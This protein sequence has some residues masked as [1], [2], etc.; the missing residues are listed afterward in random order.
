MS[1]KIHD[2]EEVEGVKALEG[3]CRK[4]ESEAAYWEAQYRVLDRHRNAHIASVAFALGLVMIIVG[5]ALFG[6]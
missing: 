6:R 1:D 2:A 5:S 4:A 3:R